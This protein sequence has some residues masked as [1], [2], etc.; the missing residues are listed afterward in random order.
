MDCPRC[1]K[2]MRTAKDAAKTVLC[3]LPCGVVQEQP[4][5]QTL[6]QLAQ[7][8]NQQGPERRAAVQGKL[9]GLDPGR[10]VV[11]V[12]VAEKDLQAQVVAAL[13]ARGYEVLEVGK[14]RQGV[15]CSQCGTFTVATG[16]QG[17]TPGTPDL[18]IRGAAWPVGVW[19]DVE[20]KGSGT[21]ISADQQA[22]C[23]RGGSYICRS[24]EEV[25]AAVQ[26][27]DEILLVAR[28]GH[29]LPTAGR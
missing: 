27:T 12:K 11:T 8:L 9:P 2:P 22:L 25:W 3:C 5:A 24:W 10:Q 18:Q 26:S 6:Q 28:D 21:P 1:K 29:A 17:N 23:D 15:R 20:L 4:E 16:W 19:L 14:S 13:Q 7:R